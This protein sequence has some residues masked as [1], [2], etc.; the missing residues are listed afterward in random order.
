MMKTEDIKAFIKF[1]K[2]VLKRKTINGIEDYFI[3]IGDRHFTFLEHIKRT[4]KWHLHCELKPRYM[5]KWNCVT[6]LNGLPDTFAGRRDVVL[7]KR[8]LLE[9]CWNK[10]HIQLCE[11]FQKMR[12]NNTEKP[13]TEEKPCCQITV[14]IQCLN[15]IKTAVV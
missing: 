1:H 7:N 9:D 5:P 13:K 2:A 6:E 10:W 15:F 11:E 8:R 4:D 14:Y 3:E 12:Q